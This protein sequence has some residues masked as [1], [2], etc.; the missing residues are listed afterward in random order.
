MM[1][2]SLADAGGIFAGAETWLTK[3]HGIRNG[4]KG[5]VR[6]IRVHGTTNPHDTPWDE[7]LEC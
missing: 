3:Y 2:I 5:I 7:A 6:G 4:A 1:F